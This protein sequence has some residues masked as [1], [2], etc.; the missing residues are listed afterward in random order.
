M[1]SFDKKKCFSILVAIIFL[2]VFIFIVNNLN[3]TYEVIAVNSPLEIVVD[4][5]KNGVADDGETISILSGYNVILKDDVHEL[6]SKY[7][8]DNKVLYAFS[9]LSNGF[10]SELLL[11]KKVSVSSDNNEVVIYI[12]NESYN[13]KLLKSGYLFKDDKPVDEA[14]FQ[15]RLNQINKSDYKIYNARSAKYHELDCEFGLKSRLG[16]LIPKRYIPKSAK[17]CKVCSSF[18]KE[19]DKPNNCARSSLSSIKS[20]G[21]IKLFITD[22]TT[23]LKPDRNCSTDVCKALISQIDSAQNTI[24][25]AIYGYDRVPK[26]EQALQNA[27]NRGVVIRLVYDINSNDT[28]IYKHTKEFANFI[29]NS[30]CDKAPFDYSEKVRYTNYLMHNKFYIFDDS[31]VLTGSANLSFTDMSGYNTNSVLLIKSQKV[32]E[33][34]KAEFEQMYSSKF[35][36]LKNMIPDKTNI[37]IGNSIISVYFSPMDLSIQKVLIPLINNAKKY[38]YMPVFLITDYRLSQALVSAKGRGVDVRVIVDATN[39]SGKYS[40]HKFLR[41]NGILVKTENYAG[42]LHSKSI[43]IDDEYTVIG[44]MNFSKSGESRNDENLILLKN[45]EI[46]IFYKKFFNY[47]WSKIDNYWLTHDVSSESVYSKGSCCDGI[48][49]DYDGKTDMEDE[50]CRIK[51]ILNLK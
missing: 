32:A 27:I 33:I 43:I 47:L 11:D 6:S 17:P 36:N 21:D 1:L 3:K 49:N 38:I 41:E 30:V 10:A 25:I 14:S 39:A 18:D 7:S 35:H 5:N 46:A 26:I 50:A 29:T 44:S 8:L 15:H 31:V 13:D 12:G 34:Y 40:K 42:K 24:D 48:D 16:V 9:Y 22:F 28:N 51:P 19:F 4:F 37:Q 20:I 45:S 2:V 23:K